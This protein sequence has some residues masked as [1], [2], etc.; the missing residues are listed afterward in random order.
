MTT[1]FP[2]NEEGVVEV[3]SSRLFG[4]LFDDN[5]VNFRVVNFGVV[6]GEASVT[7]SKIID[8]SGSRFISQTF[9]SAKAY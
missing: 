9:T 5:F 8:R 1:V 2:A 3:T 4:F 7:E 6:V